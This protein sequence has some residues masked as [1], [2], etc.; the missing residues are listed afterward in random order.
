MYQCVCVSVIEVMM[1]MKLF[2]IEVIR[3]FVAA[4]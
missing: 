2:S 3:G 1:M 4:G